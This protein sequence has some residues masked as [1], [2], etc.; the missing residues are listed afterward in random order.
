MKPETK[1]RLVGL[2]PRARWHHPK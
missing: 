1:N 2:E